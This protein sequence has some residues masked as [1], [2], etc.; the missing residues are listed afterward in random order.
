LSAKA[1]AS[2]ST[3]LAEMRD[4]LS[5]AAGRTLR[6]VDELR[7]V[8]EEDRVNFRE[9]LQQTNTAIAGIDAT[10]AVLQQIVRARNSD[11]DQPQ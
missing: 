4:S 11:G 7:E 5:E 6:A 9:Q 8:V 1:I 2:N 10:L 3:Q